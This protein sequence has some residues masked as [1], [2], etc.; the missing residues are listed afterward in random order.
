MRILV[1]VLAALILGVSGM[2]SA[3]DAAGG[4]RPNSNT[5]PSSA[6]SLVVNAD[7]AMNGALRVG[8]EGIVFFV[9]QVI[10]A[11]GRRYLFGDTI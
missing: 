10:D 5:L 4:N 8:V 1:F 9:G 3:A 11:E 2:A 7:L 6:S